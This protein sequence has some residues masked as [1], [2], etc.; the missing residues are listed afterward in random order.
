MTSLSWDTKPER[1]AWSKELLNCIGGT[2]GMLEDGDPEK[3]IS[4]YTGLSEDGKIRYWSELIIAMAKFESNL[5]PHC[6]YHEPPPLGVD[7]IG[8]LQLSYEDQENYNLEPL[9]RTEKSLENP[10]INIRCAVII[11]S[12]LVSQDKVI[13]SGSG[14]TSRGGARYWSVLREGHHITEIKNLVKQSIGL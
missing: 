10:L 2:L 14:K 5:D 11:L 13:A 7:S 9:S 4:G 8:L 6:V 1:V 3:F 12:T